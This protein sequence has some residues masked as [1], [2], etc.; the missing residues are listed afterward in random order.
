M[1]DILKQRLT[2]LEKAYNNSDIQA[3]E[4]ETCRRDIIY[5]FRMYLNTEKNATFMTQKT[6]TVPF[7]PFS[8][9]EEYIKEVRE[10]IIE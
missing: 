8:F 1:Q 7:V 6:E 9:Q 3:L 2:I 4:I 10:S 5:F